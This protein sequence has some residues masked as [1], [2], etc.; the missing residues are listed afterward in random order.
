MDGPAGLEAMTV[1]VVNRKIWELRFVFDDGD[2]WVTLGFFTTCA[3]AREVYQALVSVPPFA[4][5][6]FHVNRVINFPGFSAF[7][8]EVNGFDET[9]F[10]V[11]HYPVVGIPL[12]DDNK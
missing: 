5:T 3:R 2:T 7:H 4:G 12:E 11:Y 8:L 6:K 10:K 1:N 9:G